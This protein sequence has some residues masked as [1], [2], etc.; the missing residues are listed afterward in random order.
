MINIKYRFNNYLK[1]KKL[2]NLKDKNNLRF[3]K[4]QISKVHLKIKIIK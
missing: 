1:W 3:Q 4:M 2:V